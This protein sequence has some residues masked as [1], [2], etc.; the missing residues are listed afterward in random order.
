VKTTQ[1]IS[2]SAHSLRYIDVAKIVINVIVQIYRPVVIYM[3]KSIT[4]FRRIQ[5][6][7]AGKSTWS[8]T[9][10]LRLDN[11]NYLLWFPIL[12]F[13]TDILFKT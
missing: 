11:Y 4:V 7:W 13:G 1:I 10:K 12:M 3:Y 8:F 5:K 6:T 2:R 9:Y